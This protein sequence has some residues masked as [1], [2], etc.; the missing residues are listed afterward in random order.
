[1]KYLI[2]ENQ[3]KILIESNP[4]NWVKRRANKSFLEDYVQDAKSYFPIDCDEYTDS[5]DYKKKVLKWAVSEFLVS[6]GDEY[7]DESFDEVYEIFLEKCL[8]W[9]GEELDEE[10]DTKC[11]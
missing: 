3:L 7:L 6:Y 10:F 1:M 9:F 2:S 4:M 5:E 8:G 11:G